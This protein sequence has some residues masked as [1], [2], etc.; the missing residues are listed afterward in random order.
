MPMTGHRGRYKIPARPKIGREDT[1][2]HTCMGHGG[3]EETVSSTKANLSNH[4][5]GM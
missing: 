4:Y 1:K 5:T 2:L 3:V